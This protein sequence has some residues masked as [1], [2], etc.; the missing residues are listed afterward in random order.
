[1]CNLYRLTSLGTC[2]KTYSRKTRNG[3]CLLGTVLGAFRSAASF[4]RANCVIGRYRRGH[5]G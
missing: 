2:T 3:C 4:H 5:R 1:M